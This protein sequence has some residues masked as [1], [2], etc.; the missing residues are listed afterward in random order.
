V[1][2]LAAVLVLAGAAQASVPAHARAAGVT[3]AGYSNLRDNWDGAE[4]SLAPSNVKKGSFGKLFETKLEGAIYSQ[5]LV[6]EGNVIVTT[7]KANAYALNATTG[8]IVWKR[9]FGVPFTSGAIH[10]TDLAP[11]LG[12]TSTPVIDPSTGTVYLTTRVFEGSKV[13][14]HG[15]WYLHAISA[16]TGEERPGFPVK[17]SG[18]PYNTPGVPFNEHYAQQRPALLLLGGVVY[19]AFA[20]DC[21]ITP[22]RGVVVGVNA[23]SGAVT[24]MWSDESGDGSEENSQSGIWQSG[25]GLVANE[26]GRMILAT[27]NGVSPSRAPSGSP[28]ATLSE[29]VVGLGVEPSGQLVPNQFFAPSNAAELDA[30]DE[31]L[32]SGGPIALPGE[33]FGTKAI[34][35]LVVE[36]GKDGRIF[37]I[38]AQSMGGYREGEGEG[39]AVLQT[40]GPFG[41]VWGHPAAYGGQGGWIYVLESAGGGFLRALSYGLTGEGKPALTSVATSAES[42]GYTSGSPLVTSNATTA[43]SQVVWVVFAS[44]S[45]GGGGQLRAYA[46]TPNGATL[47]LLW[48]AKIGAAVKF[49]TPTSYEGRVYVGNRGGVLMAFGPSAPAALQAPPV[50]IGPVEVGTTSVSNVAL[51]ATQSLTLTAPV[52]ESGEQGLSGPA[53]ASHVKIRTAGPHTIPSS[54]VAGL[55]HGVVTVEQPAVGTGVAAGA[56]LHLRIRF[57]PTRPG[58][59]VGHLEIHTSAGERELMFSGYATRPGLL[60]SAQPLDFGLIRTGPGGRALAVTFSNSWN[61]PERITGLQ[62]PTRPFHVSGLPAIGTTLA[63]RQAVTVSV[64][65]DPTKPGSYRSALTIRSDHGSVTL[66]ATGRAVRGRPRLALA[67]ARIAFGDVP[68]GHT[69]LRAFTVGDSG[70]VPLEITRA[71]APEEPFAAPVPLAEGITIDPGIPARVTVAFHPTA[72]GPASGVYLIDSNDGHGYRRVQLSGTGT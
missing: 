56:A 39:D 64:A 16:A 37:L 55:P 11:Y 4:P 25:G 2:L 24:T 40:A 32:G 34:P 49:A 47:P 35:Q 1:A 61:R 45:G 70:D 23:S 44:G 22:Y 15:V 62:L 10:C 51:S 58:P 9:N 69:A 13:I 48:S 66:P 27:G 30:A 65:F 14:G 43:G 71:I 20:S 17:I 50:E 3:T 6:Y 53:P 21:D 59:V 57:K 8:A 72:K 26:T 19:I 52:S 42:F 5:P 28:P 33:Y 38:N 18:T 41:G 46:G 12:S 7:E 60:V 29:S 54:G 36:V 67:P 31:D 63:P 68:V